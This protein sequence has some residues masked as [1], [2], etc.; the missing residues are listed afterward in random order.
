MNVLATALWPVEGASLRPW[1]GVGTGGVEAKVRVAASSCL[2]QV[3]Q[4]RLSNVKFRNDACCSAIAAFLFP[5]LG[6]RMTLPA[7]VSAGAQPG[8]NLRMHFS[9]YPVSALV[10][11]QSHSFYGKL[12][13]LWRGHQEI[14]RA[15]PG[16]LILQ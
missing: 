5:W 3:L 7:H 12:L 1:C 6:T 14:M 15:T 8:L 9:I 10:R 16:I 4:Q 2:G 13:L 11:L